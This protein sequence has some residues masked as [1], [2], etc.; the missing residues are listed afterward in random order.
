MLWSRS[1][2]LLG[3][4]AVLCAGLWGMGWRRRRSRAARPYLALTSAL[5]VWTLAYMWELGSGTLG[6]MMLATK[7][8]YLAIPLVPVA[9]LGL[10]LTYTGSWPWPRR[11]RLAAI[12]VVPLLTTLLAWT[13]GRHHLIWRT[14]AVH[15]G[16][17]W[18]LLQVSYGGFFWVYVV[19]SYMLLLGSLALIVGS[20]ARREGLWRRQSVLIALGTAAPFVGNVLHI[21][22]IPLFGPLDPTV[23]MFVITCLMLGIAALNPRFL[24]LAPVDRDVVMDIISDGVLVADGDGL[25][26]DVNAS[27]AKMLGLPARAVVGQHVSEVMGP[28][29]S[30][31]DVAPG[32][33]T[34]HTVEIEG[35][36]RTYSCKRTHLGTEAPV[37]VGSAFVFHDITE[38]AV[39]T[40][41][42][43]RAR[44]ELEIRVRERT[45]SLSR[46]NEMLN[47]EI[48]RRG[49]ARERERTLVARLFH[50]QRLETIGTLAGGIAHDF[51]NLLA[52]IIGYTDLALADAPADGPLRDDL[53]QAMGAAQQAKALTKRILGFAKPGEEARRLLH[54]GESVDQVVELLRAITPR[55]VELGSSV[56]PGTPPVM[57]D[58][59]QIQQILMNLCSNAAQ[60]TG[61]QGRV[62]VEV[63]PSGPPGDGSRKRSGSGP[64]GWVALRIRDTGHGMSP[65]TL[66][67]IFEPFFTTKGPALGTGLGLSV[68]RDIVDDHGGEITV[69][70][71]V[72]VGTT[73]T[74][75]LPAAV[76]V[77]ET[78]GRT[79]VGHE[80]EPDPSSYAAEPGAAR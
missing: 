47:E 78:P 15:R 36:E 80:M 76:G 26:T 73:F 70:S 37:S 79:R 42:L 59:A 60:A 21:F 46:A 25:V 65:E 20:A 63:G 41:A 38:Q 51:G 67:R 1:M 30:Q 19:Y 9:T 22:N 74:V 17:G 18:S 33:A 39:A 75:F 54:P 29:L 50:A 48:R 45:K 23:F 7:V 62:T 4:V 49:E 34:V 52:V 5:L 58:P 55:G 11:S 71:E 10:A 66:S 35:A 53:L 28:F 72:G 12:L 2:T 8:Q 6:G 27:C 44:S 57:A 61:D 13:N 64:E 16:P 3:V 31:L 24:V 14:I 77:D 68:V 32:H 69:E 43:E 40:R 56:H